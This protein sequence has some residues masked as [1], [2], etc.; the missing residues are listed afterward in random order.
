M[1]EAVEQSYHWLLNNCVSGHWTV[2]P[3]VFFSLSYFGEILITFLCKYFDYYLTVAS[4]IVQQSMARLFNSHWH[5]CSTVTG[6]VAQQS[7]ARLFNSCW[8]DCSTVTGTIVQQSLT[9]L[10]NRHWHDFLTVTGTIVQQFADTIVQQSLVQLFNSLWNS[11]S[12]VTGT[13]LQQLLARFFNSH[14]QH[15]FYAGRIL[16][17]WCLLLKNRAMYQKYDTRSG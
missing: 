7:Q 12:T 13:V 11:C 17:Q 6:T 2:V 5:E 4:T 16:Q 15:F 8:R 1:P 14:W 3:A 9:R 10:F